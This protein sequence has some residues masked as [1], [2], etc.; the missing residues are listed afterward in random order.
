MKSIDYTA[1]RGRASYLR[2]KKIAIT[3]EGQNTTEVE[4]KGK[5]RRE[6]K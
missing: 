1:D 2:E 3:E 6:G 5:E 4:I